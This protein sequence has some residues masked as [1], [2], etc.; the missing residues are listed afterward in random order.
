MANEITIR[1]YE[2]GQGTVLNGGG[3]GTVIDRGAIFD[4]GISGLAAG[5]HTLEV[6]AEDT[7]AGETE[8]NRVSTG[9]F[10]ID[11]AAVSIINGTYAYQSGQATAITTYDTPGTFSASVGEEIVVCVCGSGQGSWTGVTSVTVDPTGT[12]L[13]LSRK[14]TGSVIWGL[15]AEVWSARVTSAIVSKGLRVVFAGDNAHVG[16]L[17]FRLAGVPAGGPGSNATD[18]LGGSDTT[19]SGAITPAKVGSV[20][21]G[22]FVSANNV[23]YTPLAGNTEMYD[24]A[25]ASGD[26]YRMYCVVHTTTDTN[27][28]TMGAS[29]PLGGTWR[30][31]I[32][33]FQP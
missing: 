12:P 1:V 22:F 28:F 21:M 9:T 4:A 26:W 32:F 14:S 2:Q 27:Q 31:S 24:G 7:A 29:A 23:D 16:V 17:V 10:T 8:S 3:A 11:S 19:F 5:Q 25:N 20:L 13:S 18:G 6:T 15:T 33:E 30:G